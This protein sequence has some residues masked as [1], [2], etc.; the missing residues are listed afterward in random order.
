[1][2]LHRS[3]GLAWAVA[4][5]VVWIVLAVRTPTSTFHF[6]PMVVAGLWV[7][8]DGYSVAGLTQ[9]RAVNEALV[10]FGVAVAAT[11]LLEA[12][13]DLTGPVFWHEGPDSPVVLEHLMFA[14]GG[15]V[16]GLGMAMRRANR[17]PNAV[18]LEHK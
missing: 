17:E 15:A 14:A 3:T 4:A 9:H 7:I 16:L 5:A 2:S 10:G 8:Y 11:L 6:A 1:M 18:H 13:G 12:M